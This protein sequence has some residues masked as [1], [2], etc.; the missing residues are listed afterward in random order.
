MSLLNIIKKDFA[1]SDKDITIQEYLEICKEDSKIYASPAE[2]ML[3]AIGEPTIVDTKL[4]ERLSRIYSNKVI[5][6]YPAFNEFFGMEDT[7]EQIVS[8]FKHAAQGLE[9]KKQILYLLGPVGGGK[10]S[11]AE[12][13]KQLM[14]RSTM[15]VL[16][17]D[18][19]VSPV[20]ESPLG[21][22]ANY[23]KEL[24]DEYGIAKRYVPACASP[25]ATK[26]LAEFKGDISK[27]KVRKMKMSIASQIGIAK[28]EP[29]DEN[30]QDISALVGK[31]DIRKLAEFPQ[32]DADAY[33]YSGSL[34][35][36]N[37]GMMEFVE[38]FK[39]P[40]KVLHPLLTA[41][42]EGNFNGTENLPAIPFQ[43]IILAHSN[44][45]EWDV[46]SNDRKNEAFLDRV[47]IVRVPYCLRV[48]E[49]VEIYKKLLKGSSLSEAPC[50]PKT[51][52][53]LA[54]FSVMTR[55]KA[56]ENSNLYS[57]M[58]IYDG[59]NLKESDPKAKSLQEYKDDA[60]VTEGM[61]GISTRFAFKVLSKVFNHDSDELAANPV[62]LFYV[63]ENEIVKAQMPKETEDFY[64]NILKS[65]LSG[66]YAEFIGDEIQKAYVDSYQEYGQNLF[67]RYITYADHWCQ[68][69]D[70]RDPETGQ[71]F[72]RG[73]LNEELEKIEKPAGIANPKDFRNDLVQFYLRHKAKNGEA[74]SWDSYEKIKNVI[75]KRI[76]SK[77]EDLIPVISFSGKV[78]KDED[79][80]HSEFIDRMAERGYTNKQIKLLTDWYLRV[81]KSS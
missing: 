49:E 50:A 59:E 32:N 16:V 18:G 25:W 72:D 42:Q 56:P 8:F 43:G 12:R 4:D 9:E 77:T 71:Q 30:N 17:A 74:P 65:K 2:R 67:E 5:K 75:E 51:L 14:E 46:F 62:H 44:E 76:F 61:N 70:Y 60:G 6:R 28:T 13:L 22:F 24:E 38:M 55:M 45:S 37:Q 21:L 3:D 23:R 7:I 64:L 1:H 10:S 27:F 81:R 39:A 79:K 31:V 73:A 63:L 41:T 26:R 15:Y 57:K 69:N 40:I 47:Y 66:K 52:D 29:G 34:C 80:K 11:L 53:L 78:S 68:D 36:A 35:R 58:R 19:E 48:N 20:W 33:N 54:Q